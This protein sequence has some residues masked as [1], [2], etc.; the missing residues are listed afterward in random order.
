MPG[1]GQGN[2][3]WVRKESHSSELAYGE[4]RLAFLG[5]ANYYMG[6][7]ELVPKTDQPRR[8]R[9][10]PFLLGLL[11]LPLLQGLSPKAP[12]TTSNIYGSA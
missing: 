12:A 2:R 4:I 5:A 10:R 11:K 3:G 1:W 6:G 9:F 7:S 8:I